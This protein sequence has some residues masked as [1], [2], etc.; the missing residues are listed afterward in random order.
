MRLEL[1]QHDPICF[2]SGSI[3]K[4]LSCKFSKQDSLCCQYGSAHRAFICGIDIPKSQ[5]E[6]E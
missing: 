5:M 6:T 4:R 3:T 1:G 2:D